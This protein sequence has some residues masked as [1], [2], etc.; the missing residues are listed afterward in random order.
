MYLCIYVYIYRRANRIHIPKSYNLQHMDTDSLS[1]FIPG[2]RGKG[3]FQSPPPPSTSILL[4]IGKQNTLCA[5]ATITPFLY[6][7]V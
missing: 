4:K 3:G 1:L 2:P 7:Q 5:N 6:S